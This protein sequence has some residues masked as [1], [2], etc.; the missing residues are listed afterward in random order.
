MA[1]PLRVRVRARA[2]RVLN[3]RLPA[4]EMRFLGGPRVHVHPDARTSAFEFFTMHDPSMV[5]ELSSFLRL[6]RSLRCLVDVG[7]YWGLFS[8]VFASRPGAVAYAVEPSPAALEKLRYHSTANPGLDIRVE[9]VALGAE[10]GELQVAID[11]VGHAVRSSIPSLSVP[12]ETLDS[13]LANNNARPDALK[14]DVEGMELDV[15]NGASA[16]L[17]GV[18]P[19]LFLEVHPNL[20]EAAGHRVRDLEVL[21]HGHGYAFRDSDGAPITDLGAACGGNI[22]RVVASR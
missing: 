22:S 3:S 15:L 18:G 6:T 19:L 8:L 17:R 10:T 20:L 1:R 7:A 14:I 2:F 9:P 5:L 11:G 4:D 13:F 12:I 16:T 21:L